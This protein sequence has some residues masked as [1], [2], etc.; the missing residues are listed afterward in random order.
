M[1]RLF[2]SRNWPRFVELLVLIILA[3]YTGCVIW[4]AQWLEMFD[5]PFVR[6]TVAFV[7]VQFTVLGALT[8]LLIMGKHVRIRWEWLRD[9]RMRKIEE[10]LADPHSDAKVLEAAG[11]WRSEFLIVIETAL[12]AV[13]GSVRQRIVDLFVQTAVYRRLLRQTADPDPS[14]ALRAVTLLGQ[15]DSEEAQA[16][17]RRGLKHRAEPVRQAA[18]K[19]IMQGTDQATQRELLDSFATLPPWQRLVMV[20]F[21]P[22]DS[23]LLPEFIAE[24]L[25]SADDARTL[26]ALQIALTRQR[27]LLSPMPVRLAHASNTEIRIKFFKALPFLRVDRDLVTVLQTGLQDSDWRVRAMAAS[28]CGHF[29][30]APL[31]GKLLE[32]CR[33]FSNPAEAGHAAQALAA[34]G[35]EGWLRLQEL[36]HSGSQMSRQIAT[37]V[38]ERHMLTGGAEVVR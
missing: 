25:E 31:A 17:V 30:A 37:E 9:L 26:V 23:S 16:A 18:R 12:Q 8:L 1:I 29:R 33:S 19:A 22:S 36:A 11:K 20:H 6:Y 5:D 34:M 4:T 3:V 10:M 2:Y 15:L 27:L 13:R 14:R 38:V 21:A 7:A 28:A 24:A 35:G 32:M